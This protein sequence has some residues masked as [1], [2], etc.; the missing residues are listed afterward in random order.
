MT[1]AHAR[2]PVALAL[3]GGGFPGAFWEFGAV[4]AL[5]AGLPEW[6]PEASTRVV[7]TSCGALVGAVLGLGVRPEEALDAL[8]RPGHPLSPRFREL[9]AV[10]WRRHLA[11]WG[12]AARAFPA[13]LRGSSEG[14]RPR[15]WD[16]MQDLGREFPAG[17]FSN[18]GVERLV[19]RAAER[20]GRADRFD[21]LPM[22]LLVTATDLDT[23]ERVVYGPGFDNAPVSLAVRGSTVIPGWFEPVRIGERD[24]VDGQIADPVHLDLAAAPP[25]AA[26]IVV[27][28]LAVYVRDRGPRVGG[29]GAA[30]V[31]DQMA[32]ISAA[33][34][35]RGVR[36]ALVRER[37]ELRFL[38]VAPE[39][40]EALTLIRARFR[41]RDLE[42]VWK[43]GFEAARRALRTPAG[44]AAAAAGGLGVDPRGLEKAAD[45]LRTG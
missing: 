38:E 45:R 37:P 41:P 40:E 15:L 19:A 34:K 30:A 13:A 43:L 5:E 16:A 36:E 42:V 10:P 6:R 35:L 1:P 12:R 28:P 25:A 22:T 18:E 17:A 7:G 31:M 11:G 8:R 23:G 27:S 29:E 2:L 33:R 4:A 24:L 20:A 3:A 39:A 21:A 26:V 9:S 32:R 14:G 44:A